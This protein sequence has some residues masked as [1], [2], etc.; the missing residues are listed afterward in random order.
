[1]RQ[2]IDA[3]TEILQHCQSLVVSGFQRYLPRISAGWWVFV[4]IVFGAVVIHNYREG[5]QGKK[6]ISAALRQFAIIGYFLSVLVITFG[7]RLPDPH[8]QYQLIPFLS[9]RLAL[10]GDANEQFQFLCNVLLFVPFGLLF[11]YMQIVAKRDTLFGLLKYAFCFT[12]GIE[13]LQ[14]ITKIGCFEIDDM[15]NNVLGAV[16][17]YLL[18]STLRRVHRLCLKIFNGKKTEK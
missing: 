11:P 5:R 16:I 4:L 15:I 17:G 6:T 9:H 13:F 8:I 10:Q 1:M 18:I 2:T 7:T 3:I 12:F 14:L